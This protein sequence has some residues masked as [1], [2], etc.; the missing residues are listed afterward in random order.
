[1][2]IGKINILSFLKNSKL[3]SKKTIV[4]YD[5]LFS[6]FTTE[7]NFYSHGNLDGWINILNSLPKI[8]TDFFD[9]SKHMIQIGRPNEIQ[10]FEKKILEENLLKL[11][12]W[13]KGPFLLFQ[14]EIDSEW[15]SEKKWERI[16]PFLPQK[17]GM[18]I[19]D[20]GCSNGYYAYKLAEL[21]PEIVIGIEKT[22]LYVIQFLAT[23]IYAKAID[24]I[25]VIPGNGENFNNKIDFDLVLSMGILYHSKNP[26]HHIEAIKKLL[27]KNGTIILET[28]ITKGNADIQIKK[29]E[30]FAGMKNIGTIFN[31]K[32]ILSL[33]D[34]NGFKNI[35]CVNISETSKDEQRSTKWM[36]GKSFSDF[37]LPNGSTIEG[38]NSFCRAI[39][40]AQKK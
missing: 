7:K 22:P 25:L 31:E 8:H 34:K 36:S 37:V 19:C 15:R 40:I 28:I 10:E 20:I 4:E 27:K 17:R 33:L 26:T 9:F 21:H 5:N 24:N 38:Y 14:T 30:T 29:G 3:Y 13:R 23:K 12:P 18:R 32:N 39:F 11:S 16:R 1:M 6:H 35:E 2:G